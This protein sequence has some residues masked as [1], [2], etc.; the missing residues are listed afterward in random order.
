M[1]DDIEAM[2]FNTAVSSLMILVNSFYDA[3]QNVTK[4]A[5]AQG[6]GVTRDNIKNLLIILS[7]FAPHLAEELWEKLGSKGLCSQQVWPTY[8]EKLETQEKVFL[9]VQINGKVRDRIEIAIDMN[10]KE[11]E[12]LVLSA[13]K[14]KEWVG[15]NSVKKIIFI[16]GKLINIVI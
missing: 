15:A 1:G 13:P 14:V 12:E 2:K 6:S 5:S 10:Q 3:P 7:P 11:V 4:S 9:I 8:N 16:P